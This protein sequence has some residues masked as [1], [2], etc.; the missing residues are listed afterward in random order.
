MM[1]RG[2]GQGYLDVVLPTGWQDALEFDWAV[3]VREALTSIMPETEIETAR[4]YL[5]RGRFAL[6]LSRAVEAVK[7]GRLGS[8]GMDANRLF[9]GE[10][11]L[12][13]NELTTAK[14]GAVKGNMKGDALIEKVQRVK[15]AYALIEAKKTIDSVN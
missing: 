11:G 1:K 12:L 8:R 10:M 3:H 4:R 7:K 9:G 14:E 15:L 13:E 2:S 6:F 5:M